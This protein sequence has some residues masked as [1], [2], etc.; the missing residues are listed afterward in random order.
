MEQNNPTP[1]NNVMAPTGVKSSVA[2]G[3]LGIFL[4]AFGAHNWYL[5]QK[6]K[7][8][9]HLCLTCGGFIVMM[10]GSVLLGLG[11]SSRLPFFVI[12]GGLLA[13]VA[14]I[15]MLGSGIWGLVEGIIL[16]AQGDAGLAAKGYTVAAPMTYA[17]PAQPAQPTQPAPSTESTATAEPKSTTATESKSSET[18]EPKSS[19][20]P[21]TKKPAKTSEKKD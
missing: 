15:A 18:S 20:K 10:L 9:I 4:G 11:A 2:A 17:Q 14:Y 6:T 5:N 19:D 3:L 21:E 13:F 8:I 16:L 1:T 7:G 12:L